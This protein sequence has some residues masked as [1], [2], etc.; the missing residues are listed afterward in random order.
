MPSFSSFPELV[1]PQKIKFQLGSCYIEPKIVV[2]F[3]GLQ[4]VLASWSEQE[5][6]YTVGKQCGS[7]YCECG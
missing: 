6:G 7:G 5:T 2:G 4:E 1:P 3:L